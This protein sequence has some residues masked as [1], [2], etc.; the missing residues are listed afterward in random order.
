[1]LTSCNGTTPIAKSTVKALFE[2]GTRTREWLDS[3]SDDQWE[4]TSFSPQTRLVCFTVMS[5][6]GV[7]CYM[8][9]FIP[10]NISSN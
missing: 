2:E 6:R 9:L 3:L 7:P 1:M 10:S 4:I 5:S 8:T